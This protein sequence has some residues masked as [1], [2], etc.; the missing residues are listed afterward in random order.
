MAEDIKIMKNFP[1]SKELKKNR[2]QLG[3]LGRY[4]L[5]TV[6]RNSFS[7]TSS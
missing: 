4:C 7:H 3:N 6:L 5:H 1:A 2:A